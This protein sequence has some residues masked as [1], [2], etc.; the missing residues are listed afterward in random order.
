MADD[1]GAPA[2]PASAGSALNIVFTVPLDEPYLRRLAR[3]GLRRQAWNGISYSFALLVIAV[4]CFVSG[5]RA[6]LPGLLSLVLSFV[7]L[8]AMGFPVVRYM[9]SVPAYVY[10]PREFVISDSEV[11]VNSA[12]AS[13]RISWET[14]THA[15]ERPYAFVMYMYTQYTW[16]VP[17]APL[18][19]AQDAQLRQLLIDRGHLRGA[20]AE[21]R[22]EN[23]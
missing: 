1:L 6:V 8:V 3:D 7:F 20:K 15:V 13:A 4:L 11:T 19:P 18:T 21:A 22:P 2:V 16:D 12:T 10:G 17:R 9:R 14:V 5:G 23:Q